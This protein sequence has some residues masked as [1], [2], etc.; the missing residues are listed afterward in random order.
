MY[1]EGNPFAAEEDNPYQH[2][3]MYEENAWLQDMQELE[4]R[5]HDAL[6]P[7]TTQHAFLDYPISSTTEIETLQFLPFQPHPHPPTTPQNSLEELETI[8]TASFSYGEPASYMSTGQN[9]GESQQGQGMAN[10]TQAKSKGSGISFNTTDYII[11]H[12]FKK[13][14]DEDF[15]EEVEGICEAHLL[16]YCEF[17]AYWKQ[18]LK[19]YAPNK[20]IGLTRFTKMIGVASPAVMACR[21]FISSYL[22]HEYPRYLT[23]GSMRNKE[24]YLR[25]ATKLMYISCP[26]TSGN[27]HIQL[28]RKPRAE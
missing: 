10:E 6:Q 15:R 26:T 7:T 4:Q 9:C 28:A 25:C 16:S 18:L 13:M 5:Y 20:H 1:F 14:L 11:K 12:C 2:L 21:T 8:L 24:E 19:R 23:V 17:A 27:K 22:L 3:E